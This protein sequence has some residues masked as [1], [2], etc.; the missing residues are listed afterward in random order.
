MNTVTFVT[1]HQPDRTYRFT[2]NLCI[3]KPY[4]AKLVQDDPE[5]PGKLLGILLGTPQAL[6]KVRDPGLLDGS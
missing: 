5:H 2:P 4:S 3:R 6:L 1:A